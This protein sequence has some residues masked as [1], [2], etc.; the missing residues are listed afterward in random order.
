MAYLRIR[1]NL[2]NVLPSAL[3]A[4]R[5]RLPAT[6]QHNIGTRPAMLLVTAAG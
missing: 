1:F 4:Q 5:L 3:P 2:R 6:A